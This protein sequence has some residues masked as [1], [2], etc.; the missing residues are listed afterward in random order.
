[1]SL[2]RLLHAFATGAASFSLNPALP[3]APDAASFMAQS[4][5]DAFARDSLKL[6]GDFQNALNKVATEVESSGKSGETKA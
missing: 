3:P 2:I 4:P 5:K 6:A 1:M